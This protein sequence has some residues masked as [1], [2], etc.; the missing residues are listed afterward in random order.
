MARIALNCIWLDVLLFGDLRMLLE[1]LSEI[2]ERKLLRH[3]L[4][5]RLFYCLSLIRLSLSS[6]DP[7]VKVVEESL[8]LKNLIQVPI[9]SVNDGRLRKLFVILIKSE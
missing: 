7:H 1:R 2:A 6:L 5:R 4:P 8:L 9:I 3:F